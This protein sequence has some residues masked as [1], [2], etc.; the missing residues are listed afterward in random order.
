MMASKWIAGNIPTQDGKVAVVTGANSGI[1][2]EMTRELALKGATVVMACRSKSRGE[3]AASK[4]RSDNPNAKVILMLLDLGD[5]AAVRN[6]SEEIK[7]QFDRLDMLIN[8][9]GVMNPPFGKTAD[10]FELQFGINHLGHFALTGLLLDIIVSTPHARIVVVSSVAHQW[11]RANIDFDNLNAAGGYDK[12]V[13]YAQSK[14]AN[15]LFAYELQRR[16]E[17]CGYDTITAAVHPGWVRT[18]LFNHTWPTRMITVWFGQSPAMGA[19]PALYA[20][21]EQDVHAGDYYQPDRMRG[22]RGHPEKVR[23]SNKSYD[24]TL[25]ANLWTVSEKLTGVHYLRKRT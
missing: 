19:L 7:S 15:V 5:L 1:G 23:S 18:N 9:A 24:A 21:T 6:F 11:S 3:L 2:Y 12:N 4:I 8:N 25:A 22:M 16:L 20:A 14:L 10:G 13:A 17:V